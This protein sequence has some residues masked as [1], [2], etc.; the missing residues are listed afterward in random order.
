MRQG[1]A[2]IKK[3]K[4]QYWLDDLP[5]KTK[6]EVMRRASAMGYSHV[7]LNK[8]KQK[9]PENYLVVGFNTVDRRLEK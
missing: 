1:T 9:I 7:S 2:Y 3:E 4:S 6:A 8:Q 5:S